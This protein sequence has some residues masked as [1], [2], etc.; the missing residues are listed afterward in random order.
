MKYLGK[1]VEVKIATPRIVEYIKCD[2]CGKKIVPYQGYGKETESEYVQMTTGHHDWGNDS[3]DS[4]ETHH[5]CKKCAAQKASEYILD[6]CG[7]EYL[8]LERQILSKNE[9]QVYDKYSHTACLAE[10]DE[11]KE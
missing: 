10:Q 3:C 9:K 8:E 1:E 11:T 4:I 7:S 5:Y 2:C 6:L